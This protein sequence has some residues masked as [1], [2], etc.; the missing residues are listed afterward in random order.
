MK[1]GTISPNKNK[2]YEERYG[3][4][5]AVLIKKKI[6]Q[7]RATQIITEESNL[8]RS[9]TQKGQSNYWLKGKK[10]T[11]AHRKNIALSQMGRKMPESHK[12]KCRERMINDNPC[13]QPEV[14]AKLR[15]AQLK[16]IANLYNNG[17]SVTP[18]IGRNETEILNY[19]ETSM[20]IKL[21]RQYYIDGYHIDGYDKT[22][23]VAYE[24][25]EARHHSEKQ[26]LKD[27]EREEYI[28]EKLNCEFVRLD[29]K[30][31]LL[32]RMK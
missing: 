9:S 21:Q 17:E 28:K 6:K 18:N 27:K 3:T 5:K 1:K 26:K 23:N 14:K 12:Q 25:D 31:Y 10:L 11:T 30:E 16:Y 15:I 22:N 13:K 4:E 7:K 8:K 19:V 20:N 32:E 2:T 24:V 29:E